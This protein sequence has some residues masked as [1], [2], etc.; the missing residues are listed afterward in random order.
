MTFEPVEVSL[1][2]NCFAELV[3]RYHFNEEDKKD[4]VKLYR[5]LIPRVHAVFHYVVENSDDGCS[6]VVENDNRG[7]DGCHSDIVEND[8]LGGDSSCAYVVASLG[9]AVDSLQDSFL[10]KGDIRSAYILDCIA[11][12]LLAKAYDGIDER[13]YE[14]TGKYAGDYVFVGDD[15]LPLESTPEIM[16]KLGQKKI[17]YNEAFALIPKKSV[18]F[19][20]ALLP[21]KPHKAGMCS[22]CGAVDCQMRW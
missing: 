21:E 17:R 12:E 20:T 9:R 1:D 8:N 2:E 22:N 11:S 16:V 15:E 5:Q 6:S 3:R 10:Q 19:K 7:V 13:L 14:L 18:L 4:I